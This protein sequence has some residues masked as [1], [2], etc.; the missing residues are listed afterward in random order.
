MLK[1]GHFSKQI[2]SKTTDLISINF[3]KKETRFFSLQF[4][5]EFFFRNSIREIF[6]GDSKFVPKFHPAMKKSYR[7]NLTKSFHRIVGKKI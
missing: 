4:Y 1:I 6:Y 7:W 3:F 2:N 5:E